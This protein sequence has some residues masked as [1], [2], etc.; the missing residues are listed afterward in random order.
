MVINPVDYIIAKI[1][2]LMVKIVIKFIKHTKISLHLL[3]FYNYKHH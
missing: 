1:L 2:K 3:K